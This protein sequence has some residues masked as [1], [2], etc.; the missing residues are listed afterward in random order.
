[1]ATRITSDQLQKIWNVAGPTIRSLVARGQIIK[2]SDGL[3]DF[4]EC[5]AFRKAQIGQYEVRTLL[6][7]YGNKDSRTEPK[8]NS[9]L[10][11][12]DILGEPQVKK[13]PT[14]S[15]AP[16]LPD[17]DMSETINDALARTAELHNLRA[18][19]LRAD[20]TAAQTKSAVATGRYIDRAEVKDTLFKIGKLWESIYQAMP[21]KIA[22]LYP[23]LEGRSEVRRMV[24]ATN[25]QAQHALFSALKELTNE[26]S[27]N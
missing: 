12:D 27:G 14:A 4:H 20:L 15:K 1:M 7:S 22:A 9:M 19:K 13:P 25:E 26:Q 18:E 2:G 8:I 6:Q 3:F 21:A 24:E 5:M 11:V 17:V 23:D 10:S 16:P